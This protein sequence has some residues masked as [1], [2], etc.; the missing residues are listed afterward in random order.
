[1][2]FK[3]K[4]YVSEGGTEGPKLSFDTLGASLENGRLRGTKAAG[5]WEETDRLPDAESLE[6]EGSHS[7][8]FPNMVSSV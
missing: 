6:K 3:E 7:G 8:I 2:E 5:N 1:M 4:P